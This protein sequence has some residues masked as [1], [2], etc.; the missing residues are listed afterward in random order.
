MIESANYYKKHSGIE[1][2]IEDVSHTM[3][4]YY[5]DSIL[6]NIIYNIDSKKPL[7]SIMEA[8]FYQKEENINL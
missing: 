4:H 5:A 1:Y 2:K 3:I 8:K 7:K 6:L